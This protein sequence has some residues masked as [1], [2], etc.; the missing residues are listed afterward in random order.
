MVTKG[1]CPVPPILVTISLIVSLAVSA[2]SFSLIV[3]GYRRRTGIPW[4]ASIVFAAAAIAAIFALHALL[5][6]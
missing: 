4:V 5:L 1:S 3:R 6:R 2:R